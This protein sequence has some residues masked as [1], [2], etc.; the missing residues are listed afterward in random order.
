MVGA[1]RPE[2][3][4]DIRLVVR[5]HRDVLLSHVRANEVAPIRRAVKEAVV[6][7]TWL[8]SNSALL[9]KVVSHFVYLFLELGAMLLP[10]IAIC[11]LARCPLRASMGL[12]GLQRR[13]S[14]QPSEAGVIPQ[15][16]AFILE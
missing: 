2:L 13:M 15:L 3:V 7:Y 16:L 9:H 10:V 11:V 12:A 8:A 5:L 14:T 1:G 6:C 4:V